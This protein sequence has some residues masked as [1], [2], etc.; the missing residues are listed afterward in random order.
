MKTPTLPALR[1]R[2]DIPNAAG[3]ALLLV[4]ADGSRQLSRVA[5]DSAGCH[6]CATPS[7]KRVD[8]TGK[9]DERPEVIGWLAYAAPVPFAI[10]GLVARGTPH[11]WTREQGTR[12]LSDWGTVA[13]LPGKGAALLVSFPPDRAVA[14]DD[15]GA[16]PLARITVHPVKSTDGK[17][18]FAC[19]FYARA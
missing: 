19:Q 16:F 9:T 5:V 17:T 8:L 15:P 10:P 7:G 4:R 12:A 18:L 1:S 13:T 6:Y 3:F 14:V 11:F 2:A